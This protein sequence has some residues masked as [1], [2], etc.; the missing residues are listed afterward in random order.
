MIDKI[1]LHIEGGAFFFDTAI[2]AIALKHPGFTGI[3]EIIIQD[4]LHVALEF[5]LGDFKEKLNAAVKITGHPIGRGQKD[6]PIAGIVKIK[7]A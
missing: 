6:A 7:N 3:F 5:G 2:A 4:K 1:F